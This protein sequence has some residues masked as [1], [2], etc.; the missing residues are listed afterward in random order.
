[1]VS[2]NILWVRHCN[3]QHHLLKEQNEKFQKCIYI[4][5]YNSLRLFANI[6]KNCKKDTIFDNLRTI[7]QEGD[8]KAALMTSI[9]SSAFPVLTV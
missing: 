9:F 6:A 7:N 8:M 3:N 4:N 1:M 2:P 5:C